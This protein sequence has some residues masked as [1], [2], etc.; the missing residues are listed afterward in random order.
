[1]NNNFNAW[2]EERV[3][4]LKKMWADGFS[5]SQCAAELNGPGYDHLPRIS[6]NGAIG[7]VHRMGLSG[8]TKGAKPGSSRQRKA[9]PVQQKMMVVRPVARARAAL[10]LEPDVEGD[11]VADALSAFDNVVPMNQRLTLL[12]L[13]EATCH[14]PIGDPQHD[15]FFFCGGR[16]LANLPYCRHHTSVALQP[17]ADRRR[18]PP[19]PTR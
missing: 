8:R 11:A 2:S 7:K 13:T 5:A 16:A 14:W 17:S 3:E 19:K 9:R 4:H 10:A 6:R 15:D 12:E 1:M 18:Q